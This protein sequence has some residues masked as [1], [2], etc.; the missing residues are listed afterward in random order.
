M[1]YYYLASIGMIYNPK[2]KLCKAIQD[3]I[4]SWDRKLIPEENITEVKNEI[5]E[6]IA[7]LNNQFPKCRPVRGEFW[8]PAY[9]KG[10]KED[11]I[12]SFEEKITDRDYKFWQDIQVM[13]FQLMKGYTE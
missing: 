1:K 10:K 8:S 12:I 13:S 3:E 6:S 7:K 11:F 4:K 5:I 2:N 9:E